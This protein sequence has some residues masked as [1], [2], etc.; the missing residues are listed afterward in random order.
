MP[1]D[2]RPIEIGSRR[3]LFLDDLVV[4]KV[5]NVHRRFHRPVRHPSNPVLKPENPWEKPRHNVEVMGGVPILD[6]GVYLFGGTVLYDEEDGLFKMWYR[7]NEPIRPSKTGRGWTEPK[8]GYRAAYAVSEDGLRWERPE[9]G[10]FE[11]EGSTANNILP[12][13]DGTGAQIRRPNLIKDF[14]DP[15]RLYKMAYMDQIGGRWALASGFSADGIRWRMGAGKPTF[16]ER[17]V[18]PNGIVFGWDPRAERFVHFHRIP[19]TE[20]ADVD[21]RRV[22][23]EIAVVRSTSRD[24]T[25][26][27]DTRAVIRRDDRD[28]PGWSPGEF[29]ILTAIMYTEDIYIGILDTCTTYHVEDVPDD[30]W[31]LIY[32]SAHAEHIAELVVSRDGVGWTRVAPH[33]EFFS[34]GLWGEWD[35]RTVTPAKPIVRGDE[36]LFYYTARDLPD[37]AIIPGL[38]QE[39]LGYAIGLAKMRL[40]G[41][42]SMEGYDDDG[43]LTTRPVVFEGD[44][45]VVNA[46][47][48]EEPF[49]ASTSSRR[50]YGTL[51]AELLDASGRVIDGYSSADCD[52]FTGNDVRHVVMWNGSPDLG[53][54]AGSPV[55]VR[56]GLTNAA[57]YSFHFQGETEPSGP[58]N[59]LSPGARGRP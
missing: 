45:L 42:V 9:L 31:E 21:G 34:K 2:T 7:I 16:F 58:M 56:F 41:F 27:G 25:V 59:L 18:A 30:Q 19:I 28:P 1:M 8:G 40:D 39:R 12:P 10:L 46:R 52:A 14:H 26:W 43:A 37:K 5:E 4:D 29:G 53:R 50:P 24:F 32:G 33:W 15:E 6:E 23:G 55:R 17:P 47:A 13:D 57:L 3:Q 51:T 22:R 20:R 54:L 44:R 11:F 36:V 35:S 49:D 48:P 38:D